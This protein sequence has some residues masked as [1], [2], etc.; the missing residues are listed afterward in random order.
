MAEGDQLTLNEAVDLIMKNT[1][2]SRRQ[3]RRALLRFLREGRLTARASQ[4]IRGGMSLG[5]QNLPPEFWQNVV[6]E[7]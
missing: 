6:D 4:V 7:D 3:A 5:P 1:G 2:K